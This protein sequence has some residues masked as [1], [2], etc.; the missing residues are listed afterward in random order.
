MTYWSSPPLLLSTSSPHRQFQ[1]VC[2]FNR[3]N[4]CVFFSFKSMRIKCIDF[5]DNNSCLFLPWIPR[6]FLHWI[7]WWCLSWNLIYYFRGN[8]FKWSW[9]WVYGIRFSASA[10]L[11]WASRSCFWVSGSRFLA[12]G[13][14]FFGP[15]VSIFRL[16]ESILC[17]EV[18]FLTLS[19][20][21]L[22]VWKPKWYHLVNFSLDRRT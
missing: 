7:C 17:L 12:S 8:I 21:M 18:D 10:R 16:W 15:W 14:I 3:W 13:S 20:R 2:Y 22:G 6:F 4:Q 19:E 11:F 9:I 5:G 1:C